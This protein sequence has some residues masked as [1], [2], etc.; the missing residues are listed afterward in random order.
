[1]DLINKENALNP[2]EDDDNIEWPYDSKALKDGTIPSQRESSSIYGTVV[3]DLIT[4]FSKVTYSDNVLQSI[5]ANVIDSYQPRCA[6]QLTYDYCMYTWTC[7][8]TVRS[9]ALLTF[10]VS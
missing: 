4:L 2:I 8:A 10:R 7:I 1:M 9:Y 6:I 5:E 3:Y